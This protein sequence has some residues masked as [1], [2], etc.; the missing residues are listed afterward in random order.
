MDCT[1]RIFNSPKFEIKNFS[2][3][4]WNRVSETDFLLKLVDTFEV[5][6]PVLSDLL[7]G[8]EISTNYCIYRIKL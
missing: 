6:T 8:K 1:E 5:I 4:D 3:N 7:Q 2:G